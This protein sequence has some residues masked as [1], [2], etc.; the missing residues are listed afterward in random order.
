M[1]ALVAWIFIYRNRG[2]FIQEGC[3]LLGP[4]CWGRMSAG[5][6]CGFVETEGC[7]D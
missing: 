2:Y 3:D 4:K 5:A 1:K 7:R 6:A